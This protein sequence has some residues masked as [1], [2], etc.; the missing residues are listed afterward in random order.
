VGLTAALGNVILRE[1]ASMKIFVHQFGRY[2][3]ETK[4][5]TMIKCEDN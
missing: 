5:S 4:I 3:R 1:Q 2:K